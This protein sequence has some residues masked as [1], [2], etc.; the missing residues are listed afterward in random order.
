MGRA[1]C[2]AHASEAEESGVRVR[3]IGEPAEEHW[4]ERA[5]DCSA[6]THSGGQCLQMTKGVRGIG[7]SEGPQPLLGGLW[8]EP[9]LARVKP[10]DR[11]QQR[12]VEELLVDSA[13]LARMT[14]PLGDK[15]DDRL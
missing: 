14:A 5:L 3:C 12:T 6:T 15:L 2:I 11:L 13:Y 8:R 1:E 9:C 4:Q 10:R 7:V